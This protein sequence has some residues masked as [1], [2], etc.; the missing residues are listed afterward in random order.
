MPRHVWRLHQWGDTATR[1]YGHFQYCMVRMAVV[2]T[3]R[4]WLVA[5]RFRLVAR[6]QPDLPRR[7]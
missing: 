6:R 2:V 3:L 5:L 7:H 1:R 4:F